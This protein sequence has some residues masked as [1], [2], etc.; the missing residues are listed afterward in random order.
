MKPKICVVSGSRA[1]YGLLKNILLPLEDS[2]ILDKY[3]IVTGSHLSA[4][5]GETI[6]EIRNDNITI[7]E[8]ISILK[9]DD[10]PGTITSAISDAIKF[11]SRSFEKLDPDLVLILGDRYEIFAVA[12]AA[13]INNIP[14]AHIHGGESTEAAIDESI[15]HS[16]TKMSYFHFVAAD[17]YK[18]RVI[19]LGENPNRVFLVG[20]LGI[21]S[22]KNNNFYSKEEL[23]DKYKI[24]F[25]NKSL[26]ITVH[27]VTL[28]QENNE[29]LIEEL[30]KALNEFPDTTLIFTMPNADIDGDLIAKRIISFCAE[31][32]NCYFYESLG[33]MGYLSLLMNIDG[34][35]GNSSSG[36]LEA[37]FCGIGTVNIGDR[38]TGRIKAESIIDVS[39]EKKDIVDA[40]R[41]IMSTRFKKSIKN[42]ANL[43]GNGGAGKRIV[44]I[45]EKQLTINKNKFLKKEFFDI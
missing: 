2:N 18:K 7:N 39:V 15:R 37:P 28:E 33:H 44:E 22:I 6:N 12:I 45:L 40:I 32:D 24:K 13:M 5:H 38:Q 16:I 21:D 3:F 8:E 34:V 30:L 36:L 31:R 26:S 1:E 41:Q 27:P 29:K 23:E 19:Q 10:R 17:E 9:N 35:V 20:G 43:F 42:Q 14:I 11:F 25:K 4:R